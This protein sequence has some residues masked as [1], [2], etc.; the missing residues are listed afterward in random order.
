[1]LLRW[2]T[3]GRG[4]PADLLKRGTSRCLGASNLVE[5]HDSGDAAPVIRLGRRDRRD[6]ITRRHHGHVDIFVAR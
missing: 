6:V 4:Y 2:G 1:M 3:C 5:Q